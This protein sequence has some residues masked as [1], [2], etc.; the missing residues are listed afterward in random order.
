MA[1]NWIYNKS[2]E[3]S[4]FEIQKQICYEMCL[5]NENMDDCSDWFKRCDNDPYRNYRIL[6]LTK[7]TISYN[8]TT[9]NCMV[10]GEQ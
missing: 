2:L 10:G 3:E 1:L 7:Y 4:A 9:V 6:V 8:D 5:D